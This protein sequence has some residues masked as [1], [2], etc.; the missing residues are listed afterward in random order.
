MKAFTVKLSLEAA[1]VLL[2]CLSYGENAISQE[3]GQSGVASIIEENVRLI[4]EQ[5]C[6][7]VSKLIIQDTLD[8]KNKA[9]RAERQDVDLE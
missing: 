1:C 4:R 6:R 9:E 5:V 7:Q 8:C 3:E 2:R